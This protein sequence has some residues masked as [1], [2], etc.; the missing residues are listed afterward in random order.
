MTDNFC[1]NCGQ[2]VNE[3]LTKLQIVFSYIK[4]MILFIGLIMFGVYI[5]IYG[6]H[7]E[8]LGHRET[9]FRTFI[10]EPT[11][12]A[13]SEFNKNDSVV[14]NITEFCNV[15]KYSV[16]QQV[17]CVVAQVRGFYNYTLENE[18]QRPALKTATETKETGGVCRDYAIL[19]DSIF[20]NLGFKTDFVFT[21]THVFNTIWKPS[22]E[23]TLY[24]T[25]DMTYFKC[26]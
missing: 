20:S 11:Y 1:R 26:R 12:I 23:G 3:K 8:I 4:I 18:S 21:D 14:V 22:D 2:K 7:F 10:V 19:Y 15:D 25:V 6:Y 17:A 5:G 24:C 13:Y 9:A 16:E